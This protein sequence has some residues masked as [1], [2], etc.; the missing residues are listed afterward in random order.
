MQIVALVHICARLGISLISYLWRFRSF[1]VK[2]FLSHWPQTNFLSR[3]PFMVLDPAWTFRW[4]ISSSC[5]YKY[6]YKSSAPPA[7]TNTNHQLL[8]QI[9]I[10]IISSSW[11]YKY[12]YSYQSSAPPAQMWIINQ[13]N[14]RKI[15][16]SK[17]SFYRFCSQAGPLL[18]S[19]SPNK[20]N[21][22]YS[23]KRCFMFLWHSLVAEYLIF[24]EANGEKQAVTQ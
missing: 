3:D 10:K 6:N 17:A 18:Q 8:L 19:A 1:L 4:F 2:N 21:T 12:R 16:D 9:Q 24:Y 7:D 11:K 22:Y 15:P 14:C 13:Q 20:R 23:G 5:K